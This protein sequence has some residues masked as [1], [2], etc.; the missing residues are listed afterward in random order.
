[1]QNAFQGEE[2]KRKLFLMVNHSRC[3]DARLNFECP[4]WMLVGPRE[5][6]EKHTVQTLAAVK[7]CVTRGVHA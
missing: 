1:M 6:Q 7:V 5:T 2:K 4:R 3:W